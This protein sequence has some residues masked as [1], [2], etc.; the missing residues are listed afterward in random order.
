MSINMYKQYHTCCLNNITHV[1]FERHTIPR[2]FNMC[3]KS[4][5]ISIVEPQGSDAIYLLFPL[6]SNITRLAWCAEILHPQPPSLYLGTATAVG[7]AP[8][9]GDAAILVFH[10]PANLNVTWRIH[11]VRYNCRSSKWKADVP[12][13]CSFTS[14]YKILQLHS[15]WGE[16]NAHPEPFPRRG[17]EPLPIGL[18]TTIHVRDMPRWGM[19][20]WIPGDSPGDKSQHPA[21][22]N[23][24]VHGRRNN[25]GISTES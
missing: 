23:D 13:L 10:P 16:E 18:Y 14:G 6:F 17:K 2:F 8:A 4:N 9:E 11:Q 22:A 1:A 20:P 24:S 15:A 3:F 7:S 21:A 12:C 19:R 25:F 5:V